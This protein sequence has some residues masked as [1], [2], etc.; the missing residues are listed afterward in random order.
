VIY[1]NISSWFVIEPGLVGK[2][3]ALVLVVGFSFALALPLQPATAI[4][5]GLQRYDVINLAMLVTLLLRTVLLII[6]LL[7]GYGLITMG[8]VFGASEVLLRGL[9]AIFVKKFLTTASLSLANVD[10]KLLWEMLGYGINTFMYAAGSIV[11]YKASSVIIGIFLDTAQVS[12]AALAVYA[13][14]HRGY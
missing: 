1:W 13:G 7:Q 10:F 5:S 14:L 6:L 3:A 8:L 9:H 11:I 4:L 2:A 12:F